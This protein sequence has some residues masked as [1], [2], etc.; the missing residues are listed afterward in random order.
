MHD[1]AIAFHGAGYDSPEA[2][3][4]VAQEIAQT[5]TEMAAAFQ[6][7]MKMCLEAWASIESLAE[8]APAP[9]I[10]ERFVQSLYAQHLIPRQLRPTMMRRKLRRLAPQRRAARR[11]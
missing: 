10:V 6:G 7:I 8:F 11:C 1:P 3:Q 9:R 2:Q 4:Q 5:F